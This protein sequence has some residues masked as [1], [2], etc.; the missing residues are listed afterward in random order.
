MDGGHHQLR[1]HSALQA[2]ALRLDVL[3]SADGHLQLAPADLQPDHLQPCV[4]D[5]SG[6][7]RYASLACTSFAALSYMEL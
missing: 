2:A 6:K 4:R 3:G 1:R 5:A 7:K